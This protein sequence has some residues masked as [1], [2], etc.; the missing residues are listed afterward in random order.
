MAESI[1][2]ASEY[3]QTVMFEKILRDEMVKI[4]IIYL[5]ILIIT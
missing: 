5:I 2:S 3:A 1:A 4:S